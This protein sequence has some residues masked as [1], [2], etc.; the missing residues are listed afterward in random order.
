METWPTP[1]KTAGI[2]PYAVMAVAVPL[3]LLMAYW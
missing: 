3:A 2:L 1:S